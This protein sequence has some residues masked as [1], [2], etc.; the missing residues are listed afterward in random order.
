MLLGEFHCAADGERL[1]IPAEF[2]AE[3]GEGLT[4]T[5][6][7]ERCLFVY[8]AGEWQRLA[9]RIQGRLPLT[10]RDARAFARLLFS[11][12]LACLLDSEGGMPL[13]DSLRQY[14]GIADEAI[15]VGLYTHLEIWSAQ[16][17]QEA[18]AQMVEEGVAAIER[19][20]HLGI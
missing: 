9:E 17:W 5:R 11:G 3:L 20:S 15:V 6:G 10:N 19:L 8:P 7:I 18:R 13:P 16:R 1:Q 12:A 2:C 4:V 14:A